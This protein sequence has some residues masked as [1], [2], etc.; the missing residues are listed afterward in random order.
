MRSRMVMH[1]ALVRDS[2][3]DFLRDYNSHADRMSE[4][5]VSAN[6]LEEERNLRQMRA[7]VLPQFRTGLLVCFGF[8]LLRCAP[9]IPFLLV[10]LFLFALL[11]FF[12]F[13]RFDPFIR[14]GSRGCVRP[15]GRTRD[16]PTAVRCFGA[17][18]SSHPHL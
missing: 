1:H 13:S 5:K 17:H 2:C 11:L 4:Q 7:N 3:R 6:Q 15:A 10:R 14:M 18:M 12:C 16:D 9:V 8:A